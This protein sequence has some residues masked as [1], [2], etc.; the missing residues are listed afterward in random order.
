MIACL[1]LEKTL[2][3]I[4]NLQPKCDKRVQIFIY[5]EGIELIKKI[6]ATE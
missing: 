3:T 2:I 6:V 4:L 5:L 1:I